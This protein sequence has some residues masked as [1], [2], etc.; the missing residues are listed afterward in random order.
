MTDTLIHRGPDDEG[1]F[2]NEKIALGHRRLSIID[3][4]KA[5]HQPMISQDKKLI[6]VFNGEIYNYIE[7]REELKTLGYK[8]KTQTDTEVILASYQ[9]WGQDCLAHFNGMWA[10][11]IYDLEHDSLFAARDRMGVKPFYYY[12]DTENFIFASEAKAILSHPEVKAKVNDQAVYDYLICGVLDAREQTF[13]KGVKELRGGHHLIINKGKIKISQYW[14]LKSLKPLRLTDQEASE[15]FK[16]IFLDSVKLRLRSDVPIGT[17]LSG[18]LD[19][20]A[21]VCAVNKFLKKEGIKEVGRHQKTFS[22]VYGESF[23]DCDE[24]KFINMVIKKTQAQ[25]FKTFPQAKSL[26]KELEN[27]IYTQDFPIGSTSIYAQWNVFRLANQKKA[28]VMLDGQ[29]SDEMLAGYH[30]FFPV[31]F[32]SLK[33]QGQTATLISE[34]YHFW[35]NHPESIKQ[36][37]TN[38]FFKNSFLTSLQRRIKP[39][40]KTVFK[41]AYYDYT[42]FNDSWRKKFTPFIYPQPNSDVFKDQ[43]YNLMVNNGLPSLLRYEDR[44]SMAFSIE[45]R[46]PFL[47]YRLVELVYA[48]PDKEKI[49]HGQTKWVMRQALKGILPEKIRTRQD[50]IG[51]ATPE[52]IWMQNELAD[53]FRKTF[54]SESFVR[55]PYWDA[56]KVQ[57]S[58][59]K[60]LKGEPILYQLFWR[61]YNLE[62]WLR[63]F[64]D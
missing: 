23:K 31:Y 59:E 55:R 43:S 27:L 29:G 19:S 38:F 60:F 14:D 58:F 54:A 48:L 53:N 6:I 3:L 49:F 26:E 63:R 44:N 33:R 56:L 24:T 13:F 41:N 61:L 40:L 1:F 32:Q 2:V 4:T 16:A 28:K 50:K 20:S 10:F 47:D 36:T 22:A 9:E 37:L 17:C 25:S 30:T 64:I 18:G 62:H 39:T 8:F 52:K 15:H 35:Q 51:F 46:T 57:E 45:S 21:I 34:M 11:V 5:G 7:I 42:V 12:L